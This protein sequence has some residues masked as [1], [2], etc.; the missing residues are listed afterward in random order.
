[1]EF[2]SACELTNYEAIQYAYNNAG[3]VCPQIVF[4]NVNGRVNN[5]P[6][7]IHNTGTALI[8]GGKSFY[9]KSSINK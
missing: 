1:M 8:S 9:N 7:T 4:W 5:V 2:D 6:V 3:Y